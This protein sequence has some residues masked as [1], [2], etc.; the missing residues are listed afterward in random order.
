MDK[1][2]VITL[3]STTFEYDDLGQRTPIESVTEVFCD[4]QSVS[5]SEFIAA[6]TIGIKPDFKITMNRYDYNGELEVEIDGVRYGVYRTYIY[7]T[8]ELELYVE[9]KAGVQNG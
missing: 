5:M 4:I 2:K 6:G 1:S 9:K 8:D 7:R 3:I